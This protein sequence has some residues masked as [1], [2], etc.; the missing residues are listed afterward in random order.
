MA[1]SREK[2][3]FNFTAGALMPNEMVAV[4][5]VLLKNNE[6]WQKTQKEVMDKNIMQKEKPSTNRR[7]FSLMQERLATL[8][9]KELE[10]L[11][12]GNPT[13]KRQICLLAICKAHSIV[14]DFI[15]EKLRESF[16]NQIERISPTIFN[17]FINEKKADHPELEKVTENTIYKMKQVIF[18]ILEQSQL[19]EDKNSGLIKRPF[20]NEKMEKVIAEDNPKWLAPF[21]YS[22]QEIHQFQN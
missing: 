5:E 11:V 20:L 18:K 12:K 22:D 21:L 16:Y 7:Y 13:E 14:N 1:D 8:N 3:K 17:T 6:D 4:A 10:R 15:N 19:I 9:P 2:Y